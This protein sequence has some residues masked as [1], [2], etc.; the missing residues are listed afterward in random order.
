MRH[1]DEV[2]D[3]I[4]TNIEEVTMA[5]TLRLG[6]FVSRVFLGRRRFQGLSVS[7]TYR[8]AK[9]LVEQEKRKEADLQVSFN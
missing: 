7:R 9:G 4:L 2:F 1:S 3:D 8:L 6:L 5:A